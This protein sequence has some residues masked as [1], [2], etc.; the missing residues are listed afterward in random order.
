MLPCIYFVP[1]SF[2]YFQTSGSL[3]SWQTLGQ[4]YYG[5]LESRGLLTAQAKEKV[6]QLTDHLT[7]TREKVNALYRLLGETTRY[8]SIQ[9]GIGGY[10]PMTAGEVWSKGFGDCKGL[11]NYMSALLGEAGI[12]SVYTLVSTSHKRL[13]KDLPNFQQLN[14]VVLMIP[15]DKDTLWMECTNPQLPLGY[16]HPDIA[17]HDAVCITAEGGRLVQVPQYA[18]SLN[19][20][21]A[22]VHV[23]LAADGAAD[24]SLR[25][26]NY[27]D[28]ITDVWTISKMERKKQE[29]AVARRYQLPECTI[30]HLVTANGPTPVSTVCIDAHSRRYAKASGKRLFVN[31]NPLKVEAP[32]PPL[33]TRK[34]DYVCEGYRNQERLIVE[35]PTGVE[36]ETMPADVVLTTPY[37]FLTQQVTASPQQVVIE[38]TLHINSGVWPSSSAAEIAAFFKAVNQHLQGRIILRTHDHLQ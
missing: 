31:L 1:Q 15:D 6:H 3:Q 4:W 13:I 22:E 10:Q 2:S 26:E 38:R 33:P 16:I 27:Y 17:G 25:D 12:R 23:R 29:E 8:V 32:A 18:D 14:H 19:L 21:R 28:R 11:A 9:L 5:L 35:L 30:N 20:R 36:M 34:Y 24:I 37:G 7:S